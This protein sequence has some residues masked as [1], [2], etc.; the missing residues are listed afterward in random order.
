MID[1]MLGHG[2]N[3]NGDPDLMSPLVGAALKGGA[4]RLSTMRYLLEKGADIR[5]H[6]CGRMELATAAAEGG[7][8]VVELL[9]A[10]VDPQPVLD[11]SLRI[12]DPHIARMLKD[13][14]LRNLGQGSRAC[15]L[16][17]D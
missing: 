9:N 8:E 7:K 4:N 3:I 13:Y 15:P 11:S 17:L 1:L 5:F 14:A 6:D 10:G 12:P 2:A 16:V